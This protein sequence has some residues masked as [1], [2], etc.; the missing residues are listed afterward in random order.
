MAGVCSFAL[1]VDIGW[2]EDVLSVGLWAELGLEFVLRPRSMNQPGLGRRF[3]QG[4]APGVEEA[5]AELRLKV[6]VTS[7][8]GRRPTL[9]GWLLVSARSHN[10]RANG[11]RDGS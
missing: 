3:R 9:Y 11:E 8:C 7:S 6:L 5:P 10:W 1:R 4:H 2:R